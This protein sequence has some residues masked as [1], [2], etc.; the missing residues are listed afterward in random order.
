MP[1]G[2]N[3]NIICMFA[4][5]LQVLCL[6]SIGVTSFLIPST[7]RHDASR[8]LQSES[9]HHHLKS[10]QEDVEMPIW[11]GA[12]MEGCVC[13]VTGASRG[14]G[15]GIAIELGQAGA[16]VYITGT[17]SSSQSSSDSSSLFVTNDVVGGPGSETIE[18]T[19]L[20]VTKAGGHGIPGEYSFFNQ[21]FIP[22]RFSLGSSLKSRFS[23]M[24]S[25]T[26]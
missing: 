7:V 16:T 4:S 15:K 26:R 13:L 25:F 20:E 18:Q 1:S 6:Y 11:S 21:H 12:S 23:V 10:T 8:S 24:R 22:P 5:I 2:F 9:R 3:H 17:S 14:I 19:A